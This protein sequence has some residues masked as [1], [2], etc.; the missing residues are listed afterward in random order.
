[1]KEVA[2]QLATKTTEAKDLQTNLNRV[3]IELEGA[4][5]QLKIAQQAAA[6]AKQQSAITVSDNKAYV[7]SLNSV[8]SYFS[9]IEIS[10]FDKW[11]RS[12]C[13]CRC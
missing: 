7:R 9:Y 6:E 1:M 5:S 11:W 10:H 8:F 12:S 13:S 3:K 2:A 4:Q